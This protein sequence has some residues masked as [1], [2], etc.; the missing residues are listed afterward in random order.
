LR[1]RWEEA[2]R[3][4]AGS[5]AERREGWL[6]VERRAASVAA[7][8]EA[9]EARRPEVVVRAA[10]ER[11]LADRVRETSA[12]AVRPCPRCET[13]N[14]EGSHFCSICAARLGD[15]RPDFAGSV[16][17]M[18]EL[19]RHFE[20]FSTGMQAGQELIGL[21]RGLASGVEAFTTSVEDVLESEKKYPLPK[22][23][24]DVPAAS[25]E[26]GRSFD[27][28]AEAVGD[29]LSVHPVVFAER[30]RGLVD[31]VL[32][33]DAIKAYFETMGEELSRQAEAQW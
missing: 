19:N 4:H 25:L 13:R 29:D 3:E 1:L 24:I 27:R 32:T 22:L 30:V 10:V 7:T 26:F 2:D 12:E 18:A 6:E 16:E 8:L 20:R 33:E 9:L 23:D 28:L 17:E 14:P 21:V 15:D 31:G 11:V 5:E